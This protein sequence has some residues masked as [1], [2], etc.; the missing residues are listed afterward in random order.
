MLINTRTTNLYK[1]LNIGPNKLKVAPNVP[2]FKKIRRYHL[3]SGVGKGTR[4]W[5]GESDDFS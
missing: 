3:Q 2:N 5:V 1:L 4:Y